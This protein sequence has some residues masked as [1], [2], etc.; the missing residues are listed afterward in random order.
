MGHTRN[1]TCISQFFN[2]SFVCLNLIY[3]PLSSRHPIYILPHQRSNVLPQIEVAKVIFFFLVSCRALCKMACRQ[4]WFKA[5]FPFSL[6][7]TS[8]V[9]YLRQINRKTSFISSRFGVDLLRKQL[10]KRLF[11]NYKFSKLAYA[12]PETLLLIITYHYIVHHY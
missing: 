9:T 6:S 5:S 3:P 2:F 10:S 4:K 12:F 11:Y 8:I 1:S 7:S